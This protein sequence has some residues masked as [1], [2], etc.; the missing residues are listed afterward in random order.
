MTRDEAEALKPR[1]EAALA[2]AG[3]PD[4]GVYVAPSGDGTSVWIEGDSCP[5]EAMWTAFLIAGS[6]V[7]ANQTLSCW[8]C[9]SGGLGSIRDCDHDPWMS[10]R[11]RLERRAS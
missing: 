1:V 5:P 8:S 2:E 4:A 6:Y 9:W 11:P 7:D 10:E 3:Y